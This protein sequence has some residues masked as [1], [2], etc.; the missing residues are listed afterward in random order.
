M[1][2]IAENIDKS[3]KLKSEKEI[4]VLKNVSIEI[5]NGDFIA[6]MGPSGAGKSTF[7]HIL[8]SIDKPDSGKVVFYKDEK[9]FDIYKMKS[10]ELSLFRNKNI[11]FIFQQ[12]HLLPEF[13]ALENIFIPALI[14]GEGVKKSKNKAIELLKKVGMNDRANHKPSEL[15][16]GESQRVAIARALMNNPSVVFA[17]EP[18]GNLDLDNSKNILDLL[19]EMKKEYDLTLIM[20]THSNEVAARA[21]KI[22]NIVDGK[23]KG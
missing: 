16:G 15:S 10:D 12:F 21:K 17:D 22:I 13:T 14:K 23:F 19:D 2:I 7:L 3:F 8:G 20:A 6:L 11:G 5:L 1:N 9:E 4:Q 18:T